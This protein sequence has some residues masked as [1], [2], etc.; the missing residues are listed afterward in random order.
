MWPVGLTAE[1]SQGQS[2]PGTPKW[3]G[4]K[5]S[6]QLTAER[7]GLDAPALTRAACGLILD[8]CQLPSRSGRRQSDDAS[9]LA[10]RIVVVD[11]HP[12]VCDGVVL[13]LSRQDRAE[14]V[15]TAFSGAVAIEV[16]RASAPDVVLL[17]MRLPDTDTHRLIRQLMAT[18]HCVKVLLFT[19]HPDPAVVERA[20]AAGASGCLL[21]DVTSDELVD[22]LREVVR[23][24]RVLDPRL[25]SRPDL[26]LGPRSQLCR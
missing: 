6:T 1:P 15:G 2:P 25:S 22:A 11:D 4:R 26:A 12:V 18:Q 14:V 13:L 17:D 3:R 19:A 16:T 9:P 20:L 8:R 10:L 24:R 7:C 21:K 5:S 23:G